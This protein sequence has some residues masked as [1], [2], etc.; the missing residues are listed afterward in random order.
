[1]VEGLCS[2]CNRPVMDSDPAFVRRHCFRF[3]GRLC[4]PPKMKFRYFFSF[5]FSSSFLGKFFAR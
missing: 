5:F 4:D 2:G 3:A 1:M